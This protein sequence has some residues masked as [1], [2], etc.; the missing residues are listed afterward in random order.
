MFEAKRNQI[1]TPASQVLRPV[2][3]SRCYRPAICLLASLAIVGQIFITLQ[4]CH[5]NLGRDQNTHNANSTLG[6]GGIYAISRKGSSRQHSLLSAAA[7]TNLDISI[8]SQ[9]VWTDGDVASIRAPE[10]SLMSRGSALAWLG[11][12]HALEQ[13]LHDGA[14]TALIMEDDVDW[15]V[16]IRSLQI[17]QTAFAIR[18]LL[19]S[20]SENYYYG[21][22][23]LWD[24]IWLGHCGDFFNATRGSEISTIK[25]FRDTAMPNVD[26][27]HPW[28]R[29]FLHGIG[30]HDNQQRLVHASVRPLCTFAYAVTRAAAEKIVYE[31]AAVEP[32]RVSSRPCAAY[33]VRLLEGCRDEG[34]KCI[35]VNPE[36]FHHSD[37]DSEIARVTENR[38]TEDSTL[39]SSI[40]GP[41]M[42]I[43]CSARSPKWKHLWNSMSADDIDT[44]ELVKDIAQLSTDCYI[45]GL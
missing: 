3:K 40:E 45:D 9:P 33:D 43:R 1:F 11:H 4:Y 22:P 14:Q 20:Q 39:H 25:S 31:L 30:A 41:A 35:T 34:L 16:R 7:L 44:E 21:N 32:T 2:R 18:E 19:G 5:F 6:F 13:F 8:P 28:T 17:P 26:D 10:N 12:L 29:D 36:L 37:L 27:L 24:V 38:E 23:D 15:D 42:N